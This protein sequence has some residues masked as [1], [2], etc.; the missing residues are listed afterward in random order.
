[1]TAAIGQFDGSLTTLK[2]YLN[3]PDGKPNPTYRCLFPDQP[4]EGLLLTCVVAGVLGALPGIVGTMQ[5]MEVIKEIV[6]LGEDLVDRLILF[7]AR[8][9]R[10]ET[11][12]YA[13]S[14][15]N[16]LNGEAAQAAAQG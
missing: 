9:M 12:R 14:A 10:M 11:I 1:M 3:G 2:P 8:S 5:A 16:P 6:G 7:D 4:P 13:W 15:K